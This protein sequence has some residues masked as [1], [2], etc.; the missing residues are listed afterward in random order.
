MVFNPKRFSQP[1][2]KHS[3]TIVAF[4]VL[5]ATLFFTASLKAQPNIIERDSFQTE[6]KKYPKVILQGQVVDEKTGEP[7]KNCS[8]KTL[9]LPHKEVKTNSEGIFQ[10]EVFQDWIFEINMLQFE[11]THYHTTQADMIF[12]L[13]RFIKIELKDKEDYPYW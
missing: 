11:H 1:W 8:V 13:N 7:I 2:L 9:S 5:S 10:I 4:S 12:L 6:I 3:K